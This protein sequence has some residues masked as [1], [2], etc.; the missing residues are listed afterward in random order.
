MQ[1]TLRHVYD[2][3]PD[4]DVD[5]QQELRRRNNQKLLEEY[6]QEALKVISA[7]IGRLGISCRKAAS[8]AMLTM[9]RRLVEIGIIAEH[10]NHTGR[11]MLQPESIVQARCATVYEEELRARA[12]EEV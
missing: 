7:G 2:C 9:A 1:H 4:L 11:A 6:S 8:E 12:D 10:H 3:E 5:V